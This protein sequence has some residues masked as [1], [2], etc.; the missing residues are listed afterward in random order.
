MTK[1]EEQRWGEKRK[2]PGGQLVLPA[3]K[4]ITHQNGLVFIRQIPDAEQLSNLDGI[5]RRPFAQV[6]RH[7]PQV[8][9]IFNGRVNPHPR[10][11]R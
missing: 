2:K 9:A 5:Q 10:N 11:E 8:Q 1:V 7:T 3:L 6:V 4:I